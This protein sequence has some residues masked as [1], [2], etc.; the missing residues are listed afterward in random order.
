[1]FDP[2]SFGGQLM[3]YFQGN[4][5]GLLRADAP[6]A[7]GLPGNPWD[8]SQMMEGAPIP[9][10]TQSNIFPFG[11][12]MKQEPTAPAI[13]PSAVA[14]PAAPL[15]IRPDAQKEAEAAG[16]APEGQGKNKIADA[17]KGVK[18]PPAPATQSI[19]SPSAPDPRAISPDSKVI[20]M[21]LSSFQGGA[22]DATVRLGDVLRSK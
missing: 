18:A 10:L 7:R 12:A 19:R 17:L 22:K 15:D 11:P 5:E 14:S 13:S 20:Q 8:N 1:M 16:A 21:L 9:F 3:Q 6:A 4:R 2:S